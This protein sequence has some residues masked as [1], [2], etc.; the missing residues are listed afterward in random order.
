MLGQ[1][2][3]DG[4]GI[5]PDSLAL[6]KFR[7]RRVAVRGIPED[8]GWVMI[9]LDHNATTP[10]CPEARDAMEPLL[11]GIWEIPRASTTP[12]AGPAP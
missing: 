1:L 12:P 6:E 3:G 4:K 2:S 8:H 9:Y 5:G 10:L 11:G 7:F